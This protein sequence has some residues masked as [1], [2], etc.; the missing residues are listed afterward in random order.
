MADAAGGYG[1]MEALPAAINAATAALPAAEAR[2][3]P[4]T[5]D[6]RAIVLARLLDH[7]AK[8]SV[9]DSGDERRIAVFWEAYHTDLAQ[10]PLDLLA[11]AAGAYRRGPNKFFPRTGDLLALVT[12]LADRV[13]DLRGLRRLAQARPVRDPEPLDPKDWD[14]LRAA[15]ARAGVT[16]RTPDPSA[17]PEDLPEQSDRE[18]RAGREALARFMA[19]KTR[20]AAAKAETPAA[21]VEK[22]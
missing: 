19:R 17:T 22:P 10:V 4:A 15:L 12:G 9:L 21:E 14:R 5:R 20:R 3:V 7:C 8:P 16:I 11:D 18:A 13:R 1:P 6:Q 2:L